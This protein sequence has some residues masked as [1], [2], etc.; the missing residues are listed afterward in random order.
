MLLCVIIFL[1]LWNSYLAVEQFGVSLFGSNLVNALARSTG[2][3]IFGEESVCRTC[4]NGKVDIGKPGRNFSQ[5][6][7]KAC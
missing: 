6:I 4:S 7:N 2:T 1:Q 5:I 3:F